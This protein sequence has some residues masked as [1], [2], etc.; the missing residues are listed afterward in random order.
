MKLSTSWAHTVVRLTAV[1]RACR[2][3][4]PYLSLNNAMIFAMYEADAGTSTT[5]FGGPVATAR[6]GEF[7]PQK[8]LLSKA[9]V[10]LVP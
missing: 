3:L 9:S 4:A 7:P 10:G 5:V 2:I 6:A 1:G 8:L